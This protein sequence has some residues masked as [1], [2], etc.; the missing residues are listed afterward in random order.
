MCYKNITYSELIFFNLVSTILPVVLYGCENWSLTL[1]AGQRPRAFENRVLRRIFGPKRE[2]VTEEL[3]K[4]HNEELNDR[5][6][7]PNIVRVIKSR[8]MRWAGDV[9]RMERLEVYKGFWW[10]NVRERDH[11]E[12]PDIDGRII[13]KWVFRK[14]DVGAWTGSISLR[15]GTGGGHL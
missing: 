15:I 14:W 7:L 11:F 6:S 2:E 8:R 3:R 4:L 10:G 5:Y 1:K 9:A 12:D 13:L